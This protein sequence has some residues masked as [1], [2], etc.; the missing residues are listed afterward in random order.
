LLRASQLARVGAALTLIALKN[1]D[2]V[3]LVTFSDEIE[4]YHPARKARGSVWRILHEVLALR[5][6]SRKGTDLSAVLKFLQ[7][8]LKHRSIIFCLS[9]WLCTVPE[10]VLASLAMRHD[11]TAVVIRDPADATLPERDS[12]RC[13]TRRATR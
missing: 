12:S 2:K 5:A 7:N 13:A 6:G 10:P 11:I 3:G 9:D 1:N 4:Q 8:V